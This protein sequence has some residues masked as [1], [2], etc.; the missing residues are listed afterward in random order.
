MSKGNWGPTAALALTL[1]G[2][3]V[4]AQTPQLANFTTPGPTNVTYAAPDG[5][6]LKGY[7]ALP[8][9]TSPRPAVILIHEWWG[10]NQDIVARADAL[11]KEGFVVLAPDGFRGRVAANASAAQKQ[12]SETP[13]AQIAGDLDAAFQFLAR[14]PRVIPGKVA[15]WGFCF[16]GSQSQRLAT[17]QPALAAAVVFYGGGPL[18]G[19]EDLGVW[20][21]KTPMLGVYGKLD[22]N[23]PVAK[24][25]AFEAALEAKGIP[26]TITVYPGVGHAFVNS[27]NYAQGGAP[28]LAW[29]QAVEFL[30]VTLGS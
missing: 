10:L 4:F 9:G 18:Q 12:T 5:T 25:R 29:R 28:T 15:S 30:K 21:A 11:A 19:V 7:L 13:A 24:V 17:R 8:D 1:A 2:Q 16:G 14:N 3:P 27:A 23:I 6:T 26:A 22:P 20:T